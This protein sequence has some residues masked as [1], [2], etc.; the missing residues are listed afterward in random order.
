MA[1][2]QGQPGP[3]VLSDGSVPNSALR[4]GKT[5]ELLLSE[6]QA[7]YYEN[8]YR[9]NSFLAY[10][11][12]TAMTTPGTALVGLQLWNSSPVSGS[13]AVNLVLKKTA[14]F[15]AVTSA[16]TTGITLC[17][18]V[19]QTA[20]PTSTTAITAQKASNITGSLGKGLAYNAGTFSNAPVAIWPLLHNTAAI[21]TTG[22]DNGWQFDFE[23][24]IIV[25][26]QSYV[27]ICT[28]G[29]TA[30]AAAVFSSIIWDEV[31]I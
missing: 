22:E 12:G 24:S 9:S 23:G 7:R 3:Q 26:P 16:T 14:G 20:A 18:G 25:P 29:A 10:S 15:I 5:G 17:S 28:L 1:S 8:A 11:G 21:A 2:I 27:A 19:G 31:A 6:L 30:A 13:G 4:S